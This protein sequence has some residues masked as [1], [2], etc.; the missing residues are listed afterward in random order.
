MNFFIVLLFQLKWQKWWCAAEELL[1]ICCRPN[2]KGLIPGKL[3]PF[4]LQPSSV[5]TYISFSR[6]L[7]KLLQPELLFFLYLPELIPLNPFNSFS[8][9]ISFCKLFQT[10]WNKE[11]QC[12][13]KYVETN[14][15]NQKSRTFM[16]SF[17]ADF[18]QFSSYWQFFWNRDWARSYA[19]T[20]F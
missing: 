18:V 10:Q 12:L 14:L 8:I 7:S 5:A 1:M 3:S 16:E 4:A 15:Q 19:G 17:I 2:E 20:Q 11:L 13:T 9:N 6:H